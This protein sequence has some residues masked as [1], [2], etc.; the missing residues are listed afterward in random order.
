LASCYKAFDAGTYEKS[1]KM[2]LE[3]LGAKVDILY[4]ICGEG[5]ATPEWKLLQLGAETYHM[6]GAVH[7]AADRGS[8]VTSFVQKESQLRGARASLSLPCV[9]DPTA[10]G[11]PTKP[12]VMFPYT[13][14]ATLT[15]EI[16]GYHAEVQKAM[17]EAEKPDFCFDAA[18]D[19]QVCSVWKSGEKCCPVAPP[20]EAPPEGAG[21]PP[22][23]NPR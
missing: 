22:P 20:T 5:G 11:C 2:L 17:G 9:D 21:T 1:R 12:P 6:S 13:P 16:M 14:T 15:V 10:A 23:Y 4:M 19:V 7:R 3:K 18:N 8:N